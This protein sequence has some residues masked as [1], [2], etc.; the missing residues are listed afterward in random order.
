MDW[1]RLCGVVSFSCLLASAFGQRITSPQNQTI[2]SVV[3]AVAASFTCNTTA[4]GGAK[5]KWV[6][7]KHNTVLFIGDTKL[8]HDSRFTL[9]NPA[10]N[11]NLHSLQ[12]SRPQEADQGIYK[13]EING[14]TQA[15]L[16]HLVLTDSSTSPGVNSSNLPINRT[17][18][19]RAKGVST[20][21]LPVCQPSSAPTNMNFALLCVTDL[22]KLI[23]CGSD[24]RNHE[25]CCGQSAVPAKC[26]MF[27]SNDRLQMASVSVEHL[28]CLRYLNQIVSCYE[29][30][31]AVIPTPPQAVSVLPMVTNGKNSLL[32]M[33]KPP[34]YNS[35]S[36]TGYI[37][38]FKSQNDEVEMS[39]VQL[40]AS[41]TQ[42]SI[43]AQSNMKYVIFVVAVS[44]YGSSQP[45][46]S[47]EII[48][49][50]PS[51]GDQALN[52]LNCCV[53]RGV[54]PACRTALCQPRVWATFNTSDMLACYADL[55]D[56]FSCLAGGRNSS[57]CCQ[58]N[59]LPD[60]C[61]DMCSG[62]PPPFNQTLVLCV[63]RLSIIEACIQNGLA[64]QPPAPHNV[65]LERV[66][67]N[68]A[69][70]TWTAPNVTSAAMP[71]A[72]Y[73]QLQRGWENATWV[74]VM[75]VV[76][77][78]VVL[79]TLTETENYAVRIISKGTN[80][81][82]LPSATV[83]FQTYPVLTTGITETTVHNLTQCC[84]DEHLPELCY[85]GCH[86]RPNM[87]MYYGDKLLTCGPH[88]GTVITCAAD[89]RDHSACCR[90]RGVLDICLPICQFD[91]PGPI[92]PSFFACIN[93]TAKIIM[94]FSEGL[95]DN[96]QKPQSV[97]VLSVKVNTIT[98]NWTSPSTGPK[99]S[100]F[101]VWYK[102]GSTDT[103][104]VVN[105]SLTM[106]I[107][108]NL[109]AGTMYNIKV[110][111]Y[112][113]T[114]GLTSPPQFVEAQT[115]PLDVDVPY[116]NSTAN[117]G[118]VLW[119]NRTHCC[120]SNNISLSCQ[121]LCMN[122]PSASTADCSIEELKILTCAADGRDHRLC[123]QQAGLPSTCLPLC[124]SHSTTEYN[125][126]MAG[127][128]ASAALQIIT[129]CFLSYTS[130][131]PE[132]PDKFTAAFDGSKV[133]LQWD[134][135]NNCGAD[136]PCTYD[137]YYW[138][139]DSA[140]L[141]TYTTITNSSSPTILR[142]ELTV[143]KAFTFTVTARN[144][145]GSGQAAPWHTVFI[146]EL[147]PDISIAQS[148]RYEIHEQGTNVSLTCDVFNY[149]VLETPTIVWKN[150]DKILST[151]GHVLM[152]VNLTELLEGTYSC[153]MTIN[154]SDTGVV[155]ANA[156]TYVN[157]R[158]KPTFN[159]F[160]TDTVA[161]N[162]GAEAV[163]VC[164]FRGHPDTNSP[165]AVWTNDGKTIPRDSRYSFTVD[166]GLR[167]GITAFKLK[168]AMVIPQDFGMYQCDVSN[169]YG[170]AVARTNLTDPSK[171]PPPV[172]SEPLQAKN[173]TACCERSSVAP[174]CMPICRMEVGLP[175]AF[176][177]LDKYGI[178]LL[179]IQQILLCA[180]DGADHSLCC[181]KKRVEADCLPFCR[182]EIPTQNVLEAVKLQKCIGDAE[183]I[184]E[185]MEMGYNRIP[186]APQNVA[187]SFIENKI[188]VSWDAPKR[189]ADKVT[190]YNIYYN[191][192]GRPQ[193][194][195]ET[196]TPLV[197][198]QHYVSSIALN[199]I[200]F[201]WMTAGNDDYGMSQV[202]NRV[203]L[204]TGATPPMPPLNVRV[205]NLTGTTVTISWDPLPQQ[206]V[207]A[208]AFTVHFKPVGSVEY[209]QQRSTELEVTLRNLKP[210]TKYMAYVT[211]SNFVG[212]GIA[213]A[214]VTFM[215]TVFPDAAV[216]SQQVGRLSGGQTA[217]IVIAVIV[218]VAIIALVTFFVYR[219][220]HVR[221]SKL[222][223]TVSFEN[224]G[225]G[226]QQ[227]QIGG[228]S[229]FD[230]M[231]PTYKEGSFDYARLS[232]DYVAA[233]AE[234]SSA[235]MPSA[236]GSSDHVDPGSV[237]LDMGHVNQAATLDVTSFDAKTGPVT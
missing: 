38:K 192:T 105:T 154:Q 65:S 80:S 143:N 45:S 115:L 66:E 47:V 211:G 95:A 180:A 32:V 94:C 121:P 36:V 124:G 225:F 201:I 237:K 127:C 168:V 134:P 89:G 161:P 78:R 160:R 48:T 152:L 60:V 100:H 220:R 7:I 126:L 183:T 199:Q 185:C 207:P 158:F 214:T 57:Q 88:I 167:N 70:V 67:A 215:T 151:K 4:L 186:T 90:Q 203:Q 139:A 148:P 6:F 86:Y 209:Q 213:S 128:H 41:V 177:N 146:T 164:L 111:S 163:M 222:A 140:D 230:T 87:T 182:G 84:I 224:P 149:G 81:S 153:S 200:Y 184:L 108:Q 193:Y 198:F 82:S 23:Y 123:C 234:A 233:G 34:L 44:N 204:S 79:D 131:L 92:N 155:T 162:I 93:D 55:P 71:K 170:S 122:Q 178:C 103:W 61:V 10:D 76:G 181:Q 21:C 53:E 119:S 229:A 212:D 73:V 46:S 206:S 74:T 26:L 13:C 52:V 176:R 25:Y 147:K 99:P 116:I 50:E 37:V 49:E 104:S 118:R 223:H 159:Y 77:T 187:A 75:E 40:S 27:C 1:C 42:F 216:S 63:P 68:V 221:G 132:T 22:P 125:I 117:T 129:S 208:E 188:K 219:S 8:T 17:G 156:M 144:S 28:E 83:R 29:F 12:I 202:S 218:L 24:G 157:V 102:G 31:G 228:S 145:K 217:G 175:E 9:I 20:A 107:L 43:S 169:S 205:K 120:Q 174:A 35:G 136:D 194:Q 195:I 69:V 11:S 14:T 64:T 16:F 51:M 2:Y 30:G 227:V 97:I 19:C 91:A 141:S 166:P 58:V 18:C 190:S 150:Q 5:V 165:A 235:G 171:M 72:Y 226:N 112:L 137:V 110:Q 232:D 142:N 197:G 96:V 101:L 133:T 138:L 113:N 173:M 196:V 109:K 114:T 54:K 98:V 56:I 231:Q 106:Q 210:W 62:K 189:N 191:S 15:A 130:L 33:W 236:T 172:T 3:N 59:N 135:A 85:N 179:Y 39:S